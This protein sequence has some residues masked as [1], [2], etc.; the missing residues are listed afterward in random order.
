MSVFVTTAAVFVS[1]VDIQSTTVGSRYTR[2]S[3]S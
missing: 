3:T 2:A 1:N